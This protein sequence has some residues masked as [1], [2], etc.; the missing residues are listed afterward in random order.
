[1]PLPEASFC[2]ATFLRNTKK[3]LNLT[4]QISVMMLEA[5]WIFVKLNLSSKPIWTIYKKGQPRWNRYTR[6]LMCF[7]QGI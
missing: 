1:M 7:A 2:K 6:C 3:G 5:E 4:T